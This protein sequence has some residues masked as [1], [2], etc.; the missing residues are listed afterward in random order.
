LNDSKGLALYLSYTKRYPES[1]LR[2]A[3]GEVKEI[4]LEKIKKGRAALFNYLVQKYVKEA[5]K[6]PG[7]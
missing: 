5:S 3:L 4:P 6:N 7:D 1:L 2:K